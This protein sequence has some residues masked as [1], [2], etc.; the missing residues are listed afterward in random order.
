MKRRD[1]VTLFACATAWPLL[2]RAQQTAQKRRIGVLMSPK[3]G[4]PEGESRVAAFRQGAEI[5]DELGT[6][7]RT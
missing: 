6:I 7:E 5:T 4:D 3:E 1:I 2:A